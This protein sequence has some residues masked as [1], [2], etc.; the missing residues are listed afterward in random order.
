VKSILEDAAVVQDRITEES[1]TSRKVM[2]DA[3]VRRSYNDQF[4]T[5][6]GGTESGAYAASGAAG[7][8][9]Y[10]HPVYRTAIVKFSAYPDFETFAALLDLDVFAF[11]D[12]AR[13][14]DQGQ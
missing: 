9:I 14:L 4:W 8:W 13:A 2:V 1:S 5:W 3:K 7:Q 10:L 11:R 6:W 12:V